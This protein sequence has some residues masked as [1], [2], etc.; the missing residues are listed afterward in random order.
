VERGQSGEGDRRAGGE[1]GGERKRRQH[2]SLSSSAVQAFYITSKYTEGYGKNSVYET[3]DLAFGK[4]DW[5][6]L[7]FQEISEFEMNII[8]SG[9]TK[10]VF[11]ELTESAEDFINFWSNLRNFNAWMDAGGRIFLNCAGSTG[12]SKLNLVSVPEGFL[13]W[14]FPEDSATSVSTWMEPAEKKS[15]HPVFSSPKVGSATAF[16]PLSPTSSFS[17]TRIDFSLF[18]PLSDSVSSSLLAVS[19]TG[20]SLLVEFKYRRGRIVVGSLP[21]PQTTA[22]PV[23]MAHLFAAIHGARS[24]CM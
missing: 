17:Q 8:F 18:P 7:Y 16:L 24:Y 20:G 4:G 5:A 3:M 23:R 14:L 9:T 15:G 19:S 12:A 13:G 21:A 10:Y 11:V 1:G 2:H 6:P 22:D